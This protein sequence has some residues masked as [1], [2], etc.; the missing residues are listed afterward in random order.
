MFTIFDMRFLKGRWMKTK[1]PTS[2]LHIVRIGKTKR[3]LEERVGRHTQK[4]SLRRYRRRIR[5]TPN[6]FVF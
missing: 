4:V 2:R 6:L 3:G 1:R 5:D